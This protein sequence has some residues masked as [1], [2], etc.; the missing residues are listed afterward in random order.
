MSIDIF[1]W[2]EA[3]KI[4]SKQDNDWHGLMRIDDF[5]SVAN[6]DSDYLFGIS[7]NGIPKHSKV[8]GLGLPT[9]VSK[10]VKS[11]ID[12]LKT[13]DKDESHFSFNECFGFSHVTYHR[14]QE[15][16]IQ[17]ELLSNN[18]WLPVFEIMEILA[19]RIYDSKHVRLI[20]WGMW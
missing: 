4:L 20:I 17:D 3:K 8:G 16:N 9:D 12:A 10:E 15:I 7:R 18:P 6:Q 13:F 5:I 19:K 1:G 11:D 2:I 14:L